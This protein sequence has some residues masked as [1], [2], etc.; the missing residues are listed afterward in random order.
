M[1]YIMSGE[2]NFIYPKAT[3]PA[4]VTGKMYELIEKY[5]QTR[6]I[7]RAS[8]TVVGEKTEVSIDASESY[9]PEGIED[10]V[11]EMLSLGFSKHGKDDLHC[12]ETVCDSDYGLFI[13]EDGSVEEI[14]GDDYTVMALDTE[15]LIR[16]LEARGYTVS[17]Q[18]IYSV[19]ESSI[20]RKIE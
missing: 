17:K 5:I 9:N 2:L 10:F 20:S 12:F 18:R 4:P 3:I 13:H 6:P 1:Q 11:K 8:Y 15:V 16:V 19:K 7:Y 14:D